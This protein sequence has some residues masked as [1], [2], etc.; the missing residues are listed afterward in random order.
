MGRSEIIVGNSLAYSDNKL[1]AKRLTTSKA[2]DL[3]LLE[4][5]LKGVNFFTERNSKTSILNLGIF[6]KDYFMVSVSEYGRG[7]IGN[8]KIINK[9]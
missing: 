3:L 6:G 9:E 2:M 7:H 8:F 5:H 4:T 1:Q